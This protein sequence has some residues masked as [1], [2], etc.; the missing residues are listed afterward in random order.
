MDW[1][2]PLSLEVGRTHVMMRQEM[3][4]LMHNFGAD[5]IEHYFVGHLIAAPSGVKSIVEVRH[6]QVKGTLKS[7]LYIRMGFAAVMNLAH[8]QA[9]QVRLTVFC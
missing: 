1:I 2:S 4:R 7:L 5:S 3:T 8:S 9:L 6:P